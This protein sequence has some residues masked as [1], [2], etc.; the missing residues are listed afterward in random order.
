MLKKLFRRY[1]SDN[2]KRISEEV[3]NQLPPQKYERFKWV[4]TIDEEGNEHQE[5]VIT[6]ED[7]EIAGKVQDYKLQN[8]LRLGINLNE[9]YVMP[10]ESVIDKAEGWAK[11]IIERYEKLEELG[12]IKHNEQ[13]VETNVEQINN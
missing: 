3:E 6:D 7:E 2:E 8:L 4:T 13:T 5:P 1:V 12:K 9:L 10:N 11:K